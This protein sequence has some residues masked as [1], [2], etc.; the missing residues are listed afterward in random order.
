MESRIA[1]STSAAATASTA[2]E[3]PIIVD[4]RVPNRGSVA[5]AA[6]LLGG[7]A[8]EIARLDFVRVHRERAFEL[9]LR[10]TGD[11]A[12][13]GCRQRLAEIGAA[14]GAV[15]GILNRIAPGAHRIV[16]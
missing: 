4:H 5:S 3:P 12:A 15:A 6:V 11:D 1:F 16:I 13:G 10:F 8:E 9:G 7:K 14:L 2:S